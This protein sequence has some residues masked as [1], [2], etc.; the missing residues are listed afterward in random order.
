MRPRRVGRP[1]GEISLALL[2]AAQQGPATVRELAQRACVGYDTARFKAKDLV[3]VRVLLPQGDAR[4]RL[5]GLPEPPSA[6]GENPFALLER[7]WDR[8]PAIP[9]GADD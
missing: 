2:G 4:P 5:L 3:R 8:T 9:P 7:Y 1:M 6:P